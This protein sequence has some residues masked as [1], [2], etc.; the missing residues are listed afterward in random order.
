MSWY[1]KTGGQI[2][3][4]QVLDMYYSERGVFH[5]SIRACNRK[6]LFGTV[7]PKETVTAQVNTSVSP[8]PIVK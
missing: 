6:S 1:E 5:K 3:L 8:R 4:S 7:A 2:R